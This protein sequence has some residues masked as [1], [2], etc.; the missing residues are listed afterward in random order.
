MFIINFIQRKESGVDVVS[1]QYLPCSVLV[2]FSCHSPCIQLNV[3]I[4]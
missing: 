4:F 1:V 2:V 3:M